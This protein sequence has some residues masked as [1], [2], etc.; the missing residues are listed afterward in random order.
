[1]YRAIQ[2][3]RGE[4]RNLGL[5]TALDDYRKL[6][7]AVPKGE[8][9]EKL[10]EFF[11]HVFESGIRDVAAERMLRQQ[12]L[13]LMQCATSA[14]SSHP[15]T[16]INE[17][18]LRAGRDFI[19]GTVQYLPIKPRVDGIKYRRTLELILSFYKTP[20]QGDEA[21]IELINE[22]YR[23]YCTIDASTNDLDP[24]HELVRCLIYLAFPSNKGDRLA[25]DHATEML[26]QVELIKSKPYTEREYRYVQCWAARR[27]QEFSAARA[28]A[29]SAIEKWPEDPRFFHGR[30]L[31]SI[32]EYQ[33]TQTGKENQIL[34][35]QAIDDAR[36]AIELYGADPLV[37]KELIAVTYNT[38]AYVLALT[39]LV[40]QDNPEYAVACVLRARE[41]LD[42]LKALKNRNDWSPNHPEYFHTEAYVEYQEYL[43]HLRDWPSQKLIEKLQNARRALGGAL[44]L[45][46]TRALNQNLKEEIENALLSFGY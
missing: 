16:Y 33:A 29:D 28:I 43:A 42:N 36:K 31:N 18:H 14:M 27:I 19:V 25:Y 34:L 8:T 24:E 13:I 32:A 9:Q 22:A 4:V 41:A 11:R 26:N 30:L 7:E 2:E 20:P 35:Q 46:P 15:R 5:T 37:N 40:N 1:M 23:L 44:N 45:D 10:V 6:L 12:Q 21:K 17:E 3:R 38:L 39:A